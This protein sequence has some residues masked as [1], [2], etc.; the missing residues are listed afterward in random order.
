[1]K[2]I[3]GIWNLMVAAVA[4]G[5][6]LVSFVSCDT[7]TSDVDDDKTVPLIFASPSILYSHET[8]ASVNGSEFPPSPSAYPL[9]VWIVKGGEFTEQI[10]EFRNMKSEL[11]VGA[12]NEIHWNYYVYNG[13]R[14]YDVIYVMKGRPADIYAYHPWKSYVDDITAIKFTSGQEDWMWATPVNLS[15]TDTDTD[16]PIVSELAFAHAMT[17]IEVN[18]RCKYE[19]SVR[20][21]S[22]TLTDESDT[23]RLVASGTM[24]AVNGELTCDAPVSSITITPNVG[25]THTSSG[26]T[27]FII[28]PQVGDED[29]PLDLTNKKMNLSFKFNGIDAETSFTLPSVM[30]GSEIK[31]FKRGYKYKYNL[32]LDNQIDFI[33]VGVEKEWG[34]KYVDFEL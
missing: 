3:G 4:F 18:I 2:H 19:G 28:M 23:P 34:T 26:T 27:V 15:S 24:N 20:F 25:L 16:E 6:L 21:T 32:V 5:L 22:M 1:M 7:M 31:A 17:C 12:G 33:P 11:N 13:T 8:K 29:N 14:Q 10:T 30:G 9:G